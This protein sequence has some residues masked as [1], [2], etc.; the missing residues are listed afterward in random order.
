[1]NSRK[2][3]SKARR[4]SEIMKEGATTKKGVSSALSGGSPSM[5]PM[6]SARSSSRV[7]ASMK[8]FTGPVAASNASVISIS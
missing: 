2:P 1:M 8:V 5:N 3:I 4:S 7:W 6:N